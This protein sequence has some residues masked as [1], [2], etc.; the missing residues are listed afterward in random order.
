MMDIK[1]EFPPNWNQILMTFP[2]VAQYKPVFAYGDTIYNPF[3]KKIPSDIIFHE[4]IHSKQQGEYPDIWWQQYLEN[5]EFRLN[6]ELEAYGKQYVFVKEH[7]H[8]NKLNKMALASM[9]QALSSD[10]YG[11]MLSFSEA[12]AAIKR[13][14]KKMD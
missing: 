9:A 13:Y 11:S 5:V 3:D 8:S 6:A 2:D 14:N 4:S 7:I 10:A 12:E 1:I